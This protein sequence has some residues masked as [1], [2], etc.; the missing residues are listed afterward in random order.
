MRT[1]H[2]IPAFSSSVT[3]VLTEASILAA[4]ITGVSTYF[5]LPMTGH[6]MGEGTNANFWDLRSLD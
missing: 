5:P 3:R 1:S 4:I 6:E 2:I